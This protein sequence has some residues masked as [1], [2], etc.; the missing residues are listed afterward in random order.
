M[1]LFLIQ[2]MKMVLT[3]PLMWCSQPQ[4]N[5]KNCFTTKCT[6]TITLCRSIPLEAVVWCES[7]SLAAGSSQ[8]SREVQ[9]KHSYWRC[10]RE[11]EWNCSGGETEGKSTA[12]P[13][14]EWRARASHSA[15]VL[16]PLQLEKWHETNVWP[17]KCE[18]QNLWHCEWLETSIWLT[19]A[20]ASLRENHQLFM[21]I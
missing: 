2:A 21:R 19:F 20:S 18:N 4:W 6:I 12:S 8:T 16:A 10:E 1:C 9:L 11:L 17:S 14:V 7:L 13:S 15:G 5:Y 3:Q